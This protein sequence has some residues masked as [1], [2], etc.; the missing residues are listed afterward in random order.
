MTK[1]KKLMMCFGLMAVIAAPLA[2]CNTMEGL[3]QDTEAAGDKLEDAARDNKT[4]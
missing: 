4:Y 1:F 2:A 3:G